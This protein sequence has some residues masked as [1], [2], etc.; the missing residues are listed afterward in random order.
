MIRIIA[1][2]TLLAGFVWLAISAVA[3]FAPVAE[4]LK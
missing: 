2:A 1:V 4:A 3:A